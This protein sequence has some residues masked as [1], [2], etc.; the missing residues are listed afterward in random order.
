MSLVT[1]DPAHPIS[2]RWRTGHL[3]RFVNVPI[4]RISKLQTEIALCKIEAEYIAFL[5]EWKKD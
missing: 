4:L 3:N 5:N 1:E 2:I